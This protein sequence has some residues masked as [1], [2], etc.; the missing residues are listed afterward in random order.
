MI[1]YTRQFKLAA[2][3]AFLERGGGFRF[4]AAQFQ[5]DDSALR[6]WV[7]AYRLHGEASLRG[8]GGDYSPEFKLS[9]LNRMWS[10]KLSLRQTAALFNLGNSSHIGTW[11]KQYYS[12]GR[13]A[14]VTRKIGP[15]PT[16]PKMPKSRPVEPL[17]E[18]ER[19]Y[20]D[21]LA[22]VQ[23][24]R[25]ENAYLKKLEALEKEKARLRQTVQK[26]PG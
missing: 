4:I 11:E 21:L 22:E 13:Q 9:V 3:T 10:E 2:I 5:I 6:R 23:Y 20:Q 16:M 26:K 17:T 7:A 1:K 25:M 24:L 12:G 19:A 8:R 18:Q 14:L 15:P